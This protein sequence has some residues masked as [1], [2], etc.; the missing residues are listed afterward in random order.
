MISLSMIVKADDTEAILLERCLKYVVNYVDELNITLT[1]KNE[2]CEKVCKKYNAKVSHFDWV[3]DFSKARNF[4]FEQASGDYILWLD[5][6]DILRGAENIRSVVEKMREEDIDVCV[7]NYLYDFDENGECTVKHLKTR[8]VKKGS[9]KWVGA[10]HEDFDSTRNISSFFCKDIEVIHLTDGK[11]AEDSSKRNMEIALSEMKNRPEDP[12]SLWLVANAYWGVANYDKAVENFEKF[13]EKSQSEE[14]KY[15]AY[16]N[17]ASIKRDENYALKAIG[18]RPVYPNAYHK[19]AEYKADKGQYETAIQFIEIGL[20]LPKPE[21]DMIV[22][23]PRDY[24]YN[25]LLLLT[26]CYWR[27]GR[28]SKAKTILDKMV[29]MFPADRQVKEKQEL[30]KAELGEIANIEIYLEQAKKLKGEDLRKY[31]EELPEEVG[32]HPLICSFRNQNF[33]KEKSSGKD[34]VFYCSH[35]SKEWTPDIAKTNGIGGSEESVIHISKGLA[36]LGWN[37]TVYNNCGKNCGIH[38]GVNYRP[39]WEY[40]VRDKQDVTVLWRHPK[41]ADFKPNSDKIIVDLHDVIPHGELY[42]ERMDGIDKVFVKTQAHRE[43]FPNVAD[44]KFVI[45]PNGL[46]PKDFE[47]EIKRDPFLILNTSSPDR[48]LEATLDVFEELIR[49]QPEKPWKLAWY[50]GWDVF[51]EVHEKNKEVMAWKKAQIKRFESLK[52]QGK[53]EG[54]YMI[55][56]KDIAK[57][58]LEAG[59]FLYPTKFYEIHCI[60]ASKAQ[61]GGAIP[62]TSDYA[63]L[64][65]TVQH[66]VKV[67]EDVEQLADTIGELQGQNIDEYVDSIILLANQTNRDDMQEWAKET[68]NWNKIV[69][70]WDYEISNS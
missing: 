53:A 23:N 35:T 65:E 68:Y 41:P 55:G 11:R 66:G 7:A 42:Q 36:K 54:G 3:N 63:A 62:V 20:Q 28:Y 8:I 59:I 50:Y 24:D 47:Q 38:D 16:L 13:I 34:L 2:A 52:K 29:S 51:D 18:I 21:M 25:P 14:E 17:L 61:A 46:D 4:N 27:L 39:F 26:K 15:I 33:I 69:K 32:R 43:L 48:H 49:R 6:D 12:R 10:L 58:Y 22:Y 9:V 1:G 56:H 45:I 70:Q 31:L 30:L 5:S 67:H 57:K 40:N 37:V 64:N 44:E 19:I 60:S